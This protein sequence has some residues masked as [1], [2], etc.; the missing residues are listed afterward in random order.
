MDYTDRPDLAPC[1]TL[2]FRPAGALVGDVSFFSRGEECHLFYL[3]KRTDDPPRLP[4]NELDHAVSTDL[5]HWERLPPALLPGGPGE[6]DAT[7]I[8]G[9]TIVP[10]GG[11]YHMLYAGTVNEVIYHARSTDLIHWHKDTPLKPILVPDPRWYTPHTVP[12]EEGRASR[13]PFLFYDDTHDRHLLLVTAR[14]KE[15]APTE[16][17][18]VGLAVSHDLEHWE[19]KPPLYAPYLCNAPEVSE[20]FAL[21]GRYYLFFSHGETFTC[22]YRVA[23]WLE[24]PY[25]CPADDLL[26]SP[27]C[28]APRSV[29]HDGNR[30]LIPWV[31]DHLLGRD[32]YQPDYAPVWGGEG[33]T[34]GGVLGT[35]QL[36][37]TLAD[38]R[39][40][41]CYPE[42]VD[43]LLGERLLPPDGWQHAATDR[44]VWQVNGGALAGASHQGLA[45]A[46]L[47]AA[48]SDF[49]VSCS[50]TIEDGVA[51]GLI[52]RGGERGDTGYY[53]RLEPAMKTVSL[54]RY[55]RPWVV[56][57]PLAQRITPMID[58]H[59]TLELK[60]LLHRHV[61]DAYLD[62]RHLFSMA[63]H[64]YRAGRFGVFVEDAR[65]RFTQLD[66]RALHE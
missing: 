42:I 66:V 54:W 40:V 51:A 23:Q 43:R 15:G 45:R 29:C 57:R 6:P 9:C 32:G 49:R 61:L 17:G 4:H 19:V 5:L 30:Y 3:S 33:F 56:A 2:H 14:L 63:V 1:N 35:P 26:L 12:P 28:Y 47:P 64:D 44:G 25:R 55:P 58:Y 16:R 31:A 60:L 62:D 37:R 59:R 41:L 36:M 50:I 39:L 10:A 8:G 52:V 38:G 65:A 46:L 22:R 21:D 18:C 7:G 53:V 11:A 24:G 13:D 48:G 27:W 34:W 20:L